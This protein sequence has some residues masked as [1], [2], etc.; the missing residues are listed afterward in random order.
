M[1]ARCTPSRICYHHPEDEVSN[2]FGNSLS[3]SVLTYLREHAPVPT[4]SRAV[5][6]DHGIRTDQYK[7]LFPRR[8]KPTCDKPEDSVSRQEFGPWMLAFQDS[9][10]LPQNQVLDEEVT[11]GAKGTRE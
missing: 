3:A 8:P 1:D 9:E 7:G 5:P 11:T 6:S 10:L 2:L 4:K